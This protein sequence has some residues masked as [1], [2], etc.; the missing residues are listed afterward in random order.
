MLTS[1]SLH[2]LS[3]PLPF[4]PNIYLENDDYSLVSRFDYIVRDSRACG[5]GCNFHFERCVDISEEAC[6]WTYLA[7][8][9]LSLT[10]FGHNVIAYID[11]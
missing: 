7:T 9:V 2:L 4:Q 3:F 1:M 8:R 5:L 11:V 10:E 6:L